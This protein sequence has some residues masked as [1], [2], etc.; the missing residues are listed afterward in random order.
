MQT[1]S[2]IK[3]MEFSL[4]SKVIIS[5]FKKKYQTPKINQFYIYKNVEETKTMNLRL[6]VAKRLTR[7]FLS[8]SSH[9]VETYL[10]KYLCTTQL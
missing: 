4:F 2:K 10:D 8:S 9:I 1:F 5:Y 3:F 6:E 7:N